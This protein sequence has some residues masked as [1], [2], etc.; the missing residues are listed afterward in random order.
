MDRLSA[1]SVALRATLV[2]ALFAGLGYLAVRLV[3]GAGGHLKQASPGWIAAGIALELIACAGFAACFWGTFSYPP[4]HVS[5]RRAAEISLGELAAFALVPTG[6]A[7]PLIRFWALHR[8][9]VPLRTI[10]VRSVVH[11]ILL[12]IPYVAVALVLGMGAVVNAGP[13]DA[14]T[15][16]AL[17]PVGVVLGSVA[18]AA[19]LT[20][21]SRKSSL[22]RAKR[23][24]RKIAAEL[25]TIV[26][27]GLRDT[28]GR[29]RH[30]STIGGAVIWWAGDCAVLWAAFEAVGAPPP[31]AVLVLGYMLG[32]LGSAL[33]LP[34]G[35]GGVEPVMLG[36][37]TASG[38]DAGA[39]TAAIVVYRAIAL[40]LQSAV[41]A[42]AIALLIPAV[43]AE[44]RA[45]SS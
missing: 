11:A 1:R 16:L 32:Q 20:R 19:L 44:A 27:D 2:V 38:V 29:A 21:V 9:G 23:G 25:A 3:P 33:P 40:G 7:A 28:P 18:L 22:Q 36:V 26:P 31:I 35:V 39:G 14:P 30:P 4:H 15:A 10:G 43:R 6:V 37:F 42:A 12:N 13:G 5:R 8:G 17:A 45:A 24:W 41:G 34:G